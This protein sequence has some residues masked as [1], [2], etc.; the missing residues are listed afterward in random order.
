MIAFNL[1][2]LLALASFAFGHME[3]VLPPPRHS[4]Y[5]P[6]YKGTPD[7]DMKS[8]LNGGSWPYP[9]R[10]Y[11]QGD[12]VRSIGA[13]ETLPVK[14]EGTATHNGGHSQFALSYDQSKTFVVVKTVYSECFLT[15]K[16]FQVPLPVGA[17]SGSAIFAWTWINQTGAREYYMNCADIRVTGS[18]ADG[19]LTG[20]KLL[21]VNLPGYQTIPE[22]TN[23]GSYDGKDLLDSRPIITVTGSGST[24]GP[25]PSPRPSKT[26]TASK[27]S[28]PNNKLIPTKPTI[29]AP[30]TKPTGSV[31]CRYQGDKCVRPRIT[32]AYTRCEG[33]RLNS[34]TWAFGSICNPNGSRVQCN[35]Y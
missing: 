20:P 9:C 5:N 28:K 18:S 16:D 35:R 17:P 25:I 21:V 27:P 23:P 31:K 7:Y 24:D 11:G 34:K 15:G 22:F 30:P 26:P 10:G 6:T 29:A 3:M 2:V 1:S 12:I 13:G 19:R 32:E 33:G 8:P 4:Q 14:I